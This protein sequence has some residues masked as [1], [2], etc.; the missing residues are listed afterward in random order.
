MSLHPP[1]LSLHPPS[2]QDR[3]HRSA[4]Y[5]R[6]HGAH[7]WYTQSCGVGSGC[8]ASLWLHADERRLLP[9]QLGPERERPVWTASRPYSQFPALPRAGLDVHLDL[10]GSLGFTHEAYGF[11]LRPAS[12]HLGLRAAL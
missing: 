2:A 10:Y 6:S 5:T 1:T 8:R 12:R 9:R 11:T 3:R 7:Y 4:L